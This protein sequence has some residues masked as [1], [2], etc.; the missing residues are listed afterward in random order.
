MV[1]CE[2]L[3]TIQIPK[4]ADAQVPYSWP[5]ESV[6]VTCGYGGMNVHPVPAAGP[7]TQ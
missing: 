6:D 5:S 7:G 2:D 4:S 1:W 3:M